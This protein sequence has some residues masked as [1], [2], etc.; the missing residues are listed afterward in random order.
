[1][2]ALGNYLRARRKQSQLSQK[3]LAFLLGYKNESFVSRL[4]RHERPLTFSALRACNV[5][6]GSGVEEM[7]PA[8]S[9]EADDRLLERIRALCANLEASDS[10]K[11][12]EVKLRLL[13]AAMG[14]LAEEEVAHEGV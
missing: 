12:T 8:L 14:R 5:I 7:F 9:K 3:E 4:E 11:R 2:G 10:S 13:L 1:M 6:F